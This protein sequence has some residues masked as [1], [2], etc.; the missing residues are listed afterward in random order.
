KQRLNIAALND[1]A[2]ADAAELARQRVLRNS[3]IAGS[4]LLAAIALLLY[5]R[6]RQRQ[7]A[8]RELAAHARRL[9]AALATADRERAHA[10]EAERVNR[11]LLRVAADDLR[12]PLT[13][14]LGRAERLLML[15]ADQ[16]TLRRDAAAIADTLQ[17]LVHLVTDLVESAELE[18]QDA[19]MALQPIDLAEIL[20]GVCAH[21]GL[22]ASEKRQQLECQAPA[23][24]SAIGDPARLRQALEHLV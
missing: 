6:V 5:A 16:P 1:R 2:T 19:R 7:R 15:G 20:R 23:Q 22:R 9:E 3:L 24:L 10:Q 17:Y 12:L 14:A 13:S 8:E 21:Y 4:A 18:R 11:E